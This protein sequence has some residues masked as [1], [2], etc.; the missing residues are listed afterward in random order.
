MGQNGGALR[1]EGVWKAFE[2]NIVLR[3]PRPDVPLA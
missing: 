3:Y 1:L 2:D